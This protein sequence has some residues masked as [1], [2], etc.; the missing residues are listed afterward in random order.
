MLKVTSWWRLGW[1]TAANRMPM[2]QGVEV[3]ELQ[4]PV[5]FGVTA[6]AFTFR[7]GR[8]VPAESKYCITRQLER[9]V[10]AAATGADAIGGLVLPVAECRATAENNFATACHSLLRAWLFR[11]GQFSG[12][13]QNGPLRSP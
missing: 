5:T 10:S 8:T 6:G 9:C 11:L 13:S 2:L 3:R 7:P 1:F 12:F 4:V